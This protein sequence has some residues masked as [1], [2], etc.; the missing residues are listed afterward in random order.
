VTDHAARRARILDTL[1]RDAALV[2][3]A[4]PAIRV[5]RDLELRYRADPDLYWLTGCTEP[6]AV[7]LF[8][9][10]FEEAPFTLFVRSRNAEQELWSG[11]RGGPEA[12]R[13]RFGADASHPIAELNE[14]LPKIL[15]DVETLYFRL[16][17]GRDEVERLV[18]WI[19]VQAQRARQRSGRGARTLVDPGALLDDLRVVKD[20]DEIRLLREAC[21]ITSDGFR[22]AAPLIRAGVGEWEIEAALEAAFR[23]RGADGFAFQSIV[24]SGTNA[25]VLHYVDNDRTLQENDLLLVDAGARYRMYNGDLS[26]TLPVAGRFSGAQ[27]DLYEIVLR[28]HDRALAACRPGAT[29]AQ[30]HD[31]A[32]QELVAGLVALGLLTGESDKL[33]ADETHWKPY[34]PHQTSHWLGLDVHDVGDYA[35]NGESRRLEPGMVLTVEPGLYLPAAREAVPEALRGVGIR[36]EDVVLISQTGHELLTSFPTSVAELEALL[37]G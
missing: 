3:P 17:T 37:S 19:L 31:A 26:R 13:E 24:A 30:V 10:R 21:A 32:L 16:G 4:A 36:I 27:R 29:V 34:Y 2:L 18:R 5:G 12:A 9:P 22:A 25:T 15:K 8:C 33:A 6:E 1:G 23:R 7:A 28:A 35:R 20:A 14:R 11:G